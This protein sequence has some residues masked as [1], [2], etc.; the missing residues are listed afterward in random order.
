[1]N[2]Q[3]HNFIQFQTEI[4]LMFSHYS[5]DKWNQMTWNQ[6]LLVSRLTPKDL[7]TDQT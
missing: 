4:Y 5:L 3:Q 7:N 6:Y 1:M 2:I